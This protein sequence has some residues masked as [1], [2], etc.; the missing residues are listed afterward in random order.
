VRVKNATVLITIISNK[1]F[2][3]NGKFSV[4]HQFDTGVAW[5][6]LALEASSRNLFV[7]RMQGS[8]I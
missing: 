4:T 2:E 5:E 7:H 3:F 8:I 1:N 6:N